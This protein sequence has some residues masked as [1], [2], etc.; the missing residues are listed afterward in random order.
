MYVVALFSQGFLCVV[1]IYLLKEGK[2]IFSS[3]MFCGHSHFE[4][5]LFS[6]MKKKSGKALNGGGLPFG[7]QLLKCS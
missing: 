3:K 1:L 2:H 5:H 7:F 4:S 6:S